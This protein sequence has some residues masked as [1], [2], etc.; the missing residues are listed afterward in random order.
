MTVPRLVCFGGKH[1]FKSQQITWG[2]PR[3]RCLDMWEKNREV[4]DIQ[5]QWI[6]SQEF[7]GWVY[8]RW[9]GGIP[10]R[11]ISRIPKNLADS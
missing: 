10:R 9:F 5:S 11:E 8:Y 2:W 1:C 7:P 3:G 4:H 6:F